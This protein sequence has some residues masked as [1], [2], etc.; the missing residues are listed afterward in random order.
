M[1]VGSSNV[2]SLFSDS[3]IKTLLSVKEFFK[4]YTATKIK[5][6]SHKEQGY[7][8]T[9]ERQCISYEYADALQI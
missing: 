7:K 3:E 5:D 2:L 8:E 6:F 9:S 1:T 4:D